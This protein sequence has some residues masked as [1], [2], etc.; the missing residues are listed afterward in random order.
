M[1]MRVWR[2]ERC[3]FRE[4]VAGMAIIANIS[5]DLFDSV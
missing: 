5:T 3:W 4:V 1:A 2:G